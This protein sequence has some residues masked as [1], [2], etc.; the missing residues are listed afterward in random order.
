MKNEAEKALESAGVKL[1]DTPDFLSASQ[2]PVQESPVEAPEPTQAPEPQETIAVEANWQ[3]EQ[4]LIEETPA[5]VAEQEAPSEQVEVASQSTDEG[6]RYQMPDEE[7]VAPR[8]PNRPTKEQLE[9]LMINAVSERLNM[10]FD[11]FDSLQQAIQKEV[12]VDER[13]KAISDFVK[14][15]GRDPKDWFSYQQYN[16]SEMD[17]MTAVKTNL[18]LKNPSLSDSELDVFAKS[19]Y[20]LNE[21]EYSKEEVAVDSL[22][23]KMDA[24]QARRELADARER[25]KA[26]EVKERAQVEDNYD[27][28][29]DDKWI[30]RMSAEVD[31]LDGLEF[32]LPNG[33]NFT[34]GV[35]N[36]YKN[37]LKQKNANLES[38]FDSYVDDAGNWDYDMLNSHRT[39]IDNIDGIINAVYNQGISDGQR[40]VVTQAANVS[41][42]A[43]I[44]VQ[45]Q[46]DNR[47]A[48]AEQ[49]AS[50]L[51]SE[52]MTFKI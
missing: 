38:Y 43:P 11:S 22:Q 4:P 40:N 14:E 33:K 30:A 41:A 10:K 17:D 50:A 28:I 49:L 39:L 52:M 13:V 27:S 9:N 18:K 2:E 44:N 29:V 26:P 16:P 15:T 1:S 24:E 6:Y 19:K 25:F 37:E 48:I 20:K 47:S 21:T 31:S 8:M 51:G 32:E 46:G 36:T 34:F 45:T 35:N 12:E 23:L 5:P 3:S 7:Q 42:P